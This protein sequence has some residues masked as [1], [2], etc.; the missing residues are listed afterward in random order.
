VNLQ[1]AAP[2]SSDLN[3]GFNGGFHSGLNTA[4]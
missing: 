4:Y 3:G 1:A 2:R